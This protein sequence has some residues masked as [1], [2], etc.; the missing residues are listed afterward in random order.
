MNKKFLSAIM[1]GAMLTASTSV[2]VSCE[3]Y[4]D[5]I[6]HLQEQIDQNATTAASELAAKVAALES[7]LS[8]LKAA[9]DNMKEQ[10]ASAKAEAAAAANNALSAAQAAQAAADKAQ[11]GAADAKAAADK[12]QAAADA[13]NKGLSD[14]VTKVAVLEAKIAS[15]ETAI[16]ELSASNKELNAKLNDLQNAYNLLNVNV[17]ANAE[18]I[19]AIKAD[20]AAK[21]ADLAGQI[22]AV[23]SELAGKID[24]IDARLKA[25]EATYAKV[26][27]LA[28]LEAKLNEQIAANEAYVAAMEATIAELEAAD[29]AAAALIAANHE[30]AL[31]K[32]A[33]V[34]EE[35]AAQKAEVAKNFEAVNAQIADLEAT[36]A[37]LAQLATANYNDIAA[38]RQALDEKTTELFDLVSQL[39]VA[40][41]G[42]LDQIEIIF[43]KLF[44]VETTASDNADLITQ[45]IGADKGF[46]A[47]IEKIS[48]ILDELNTASKD[49]AQQIVE[50]I[51]VDKGLAA[52]IEKILVD[53]TTNKELVA[54]QIINLSNA[55]KDLKDD[56]VALMGDV[57]DLYAKLVAS[58]EDLQTKDAEL[59][60]QIKSLFAQAEIFGKD[61]ETL[62]QGIIALQKKDDQIVGMIKV[63]IKDLAGVEGTTVELADAIEALKGV[64][65][66]NQEL[67][68][69]AL[70]K[71]RDALTAKIESNYTELTGK[72]AEAMTK[73]DNV[74]S[75]LNTKYVE[76][77]AGLQGQIDGINA[78]LNGLHSIVFVP[79]FTSDDF[80]HSVY[81]INTYGWDEKK[82]EKTPGADVFPVSTVK[83][84]VEPAGYAEK[85]AKLAEVEGFLKMESAN[86]LVGTRSEAQNLLTIIDA[87][88]DGDFL[89]V[90]VAKA[91]DKVE[92]GS[93]H[94]TALVVANS[95]SSLSRTSDYFVVKFAE[96]QV[97]DV[98]NELVYASEAPKHVKVDTKHI[99]ALN[100]ISDVNVE[101]AHNVFDQFN[102]LN[103]KT[104][105]R[106]DILPYDGVKLPSNLKITKVGTS[107]FSKD[108]YKNEFFMVTPDG[109]IS[110]RSKDDKGEVPV[111]FNYNKTLNLTV[112]DEAYGFNDK[113]EYVVEYN[114]NFKIVEKYCEL[115]PLAF[116]FAMVWPTKTAEA[117]KITLATIEEQ[118][119]LL[120]E[121][122]LSA[123][124]VFG[125]MYEIAKGGVVNN[126]N[127][128]YFELAAVEKDGKPDHI[129][130]TPHITNV[131]AQSYRENP[132]LD[133]YTFVLNDIKAKVPVNVTIELSVPTNGI[134]AFFEKKPYYWT[135]NGNNTLMVNYTLLE[136]T[137]NSQY[138]Y[139]VT[140]NNVYRS[141]VENNV[142]ELEWILDAEEDYK[143]IEGVVFAPQ[144]DGTVK[145]IYSK[146]VT[147]KDKKDDKAVNLDIEAMTFTTRGFFGKT[148]IGK[149]LYQKF[150]VVYP[151]VPEDIK[152]PSDLSI[153]AQKLKEGVPFNVIN[154][155]SL[156]DR[157][158][159]NWIVDGKVWNE[160]SATT[161]SP[162]VQNEWG[163]G[164]LSYKITKITTNGGLYELSAEEM[165][166]FSLNTVTTDPNYGQLTVA[167]SA[168]I[169]K[170]IQVTITVS[171]P[172]TYG[173]VETSYNVMITA[174]NQN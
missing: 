19:K 23:S 76:S 32:I 112:V 138:A 60:K 130:V 30:E 9:Q 153:A 113:G 65:A 105:L 13:A 25:V 79:Q 172:Y 108:G 114:F 119:Q 128:A 149:H 69:D 96:E 75:E 142:V 126:N 134:D 28:A 12:A 2:F 103:A 173:V 38:L 26:A 91:N 150:D 11:S 139:E 98:N 95:E 7:Q 117:Q 166:D 21:T 101:L 6:A 78:L 57:E 131:S 27:E 111:P 127:N 4:G 133:P 92:N 17:N 115:K 55:D 141:L 53:Y 148:T 22:A 102:F 80:D 84:R 167:K 8:T 47:D 62:K 46:T 147:A 93:L 56:I 157:D 162:S 35:L 174:L 18:E 41:R 136:V 146:P 52:D 110:V 145:L 43:E 34:N 154:K 40:D 36:V 72:I 124:Q 15:L 42:I 169:T 99:N 37:T 104:A 58:V 129:T 97:K 132:I 171:L 120:K 156:T 31:A 168:N 158:G 44:D 83:F 3:D 45:L 64:V 63:I 125:M 118:A 48:V 20:I 106:D 82:Q 123:E 137:G 163:I 10:L 81:H 89:Y 24:A 29:A 152:H 90:E 87:K 86:A 73:I 121:N 74:N 61:I 33:A 165:K 107:D 164:A 77:I 67:A 140:M 122:K 54:Q 70:D 116:N 39:T 5:D 14:A 144:T 159:Y 94:P 160:A 151:I 59:A 155:V 71:L 100:E 1:C 109:K 66:E 49:A 143:D 88:A 16:A 68:A 85:I 170:D 135:G 161:E 50:L 51:G